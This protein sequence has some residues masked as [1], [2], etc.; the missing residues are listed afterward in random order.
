VSAYISNPRNVQ[1]RVS[2]KTL[3][4]NYIFFLTA[5]RKI[6]HRQPIAEV[7]SSSS[8]VHGGTGRV[9][10]TAVC[11]SFPRTVTHCVGGLHYA[12]KL[13]GQQQSTRLTNINARLATA[14]L[15]VPG[16]TGYCNVN[17]QQITG[18]RPSV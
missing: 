11:R 7:C 12:A 2:T 6:I 10:C 8:A 15:P 14:E 5:G 16:P 13:G 17:I 3:S 18:R 4:F 9:A 1:L